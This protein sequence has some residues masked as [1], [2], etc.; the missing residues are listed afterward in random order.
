M[1]NT[2]YFTKKVATYAII[3]C[4]VATP[5]F[6]FA[7]TGSCTSQNIVSD[8]GVFSVISG[9]SSVVVTPNDTT[10]T[11]WHA[12]VPQAGAQWVWNI[13]PVVTVLT[14]PDTE[15]FQKHFTIGDASTASGTI[16]IAADDHYNIIINGHQIGADSYPYQQ[17]QAYENSTTY[18]LDSSVFVD[19]DNVLSVSV[20]NDV[21][22][23][24]SAPAIRNPGGL[25]LGMTYGS[26]DAPTT[27]SSSIVFGTISDVS[28]TT[29]ST[30]TIVDYNLPTATENSIALDP[31][32]ITCIPASGTLFDFGTTSVMCTASSTDAIATTTFN[33]IV[34]STTS[35]ISPTGSTTITFAPSS[36]VSTTT[37]STTGTIVTFDIPTATEGT[38]STPLAVT[39]SPDSGTNFDI[40][41][42]SV[43]CTATDPSDASNTATTSFNVI[44]TSTATTT[45]TTTDTSSTGGTTGGGG[46][47]SSSFSS[48][49]SSSGGSSGSSSGIPLALTLPNSCP[50]ITTFMSLGGK[51]NSTDV[52]KLQTFLKN[53]EGANVDLTGIF[54]P[55]TVAAVKAFQAKYL[56]DIMGPW[57]SANPSGYVYITTKKKIN[58]IAC[59]APIALT[60]AE[61]AIIAAHNAALTNPA[62]TNPSTPSTSSTT[63]G[64]E[65][66]SGTTTA[67][68]SSTTEQ[69]IGSNPN[70][71]AA[72]TATVVNAPVLQ[73]L[74]NFL[75]NIF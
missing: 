63:V 24:P 32:D 33:V 55:A 12:T 27:A 19:G 18:P 1:K 6:A 16:S 39:C 67:P 14:S 42:T 34:S 30:S 50:L 65:N 57:N 22:T 25:L 51:N 41:T 48:S 74:W 52:L 69:I 5:A 58:E 31:S 37:D 59:N 23:D 47:S 38:S 17:S 13:D 10:N 61:E 64:V 62:P 11:Y 44:V 45:A 54:D 68:T 28:T 72:N 53:V 46:S 26:C 3:A 70:T 43:T 40:G 4:A 2:L 35:P 36:D 15:T 75:K 73:R 60:P 49:E 9:G 56:A 8:A 7:D 21:F 29:D 20:T 71:G 66:T